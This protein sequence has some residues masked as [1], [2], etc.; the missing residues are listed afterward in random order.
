[1]YANKLSGTLPEAL[2]RLT[3]LSTLCVERGAAPLMHAAPHV[4]RGCVACSSAPLRCRM[5]RCGG[6]AARAWW[7]TKARALTHRAPRA[8]L[9]VRCNA[10]SRAAGCPP[11]ASPAP[12][13]RT[14][15]VPPA[16]GSCTSPA[17]AACFFPCSILTLLS[18]MH[19]RFACCAPLCPLLSS[20][21]YGNQMSGTIPPAIGTM[22][23]LV[24][25]CAP[26]CDKHAFLRV[27]NLTSPLRAQLAVR[28]Q[29][30]GPNSAH[31]RVVHQPRA[32]VRARR[33]CAHAALSADSDDV[34]ASAVCCSVAFCMATSWRDRY[35]PRWGRSPSCAKCAARC[36][37]RLAAAAAQTLT[38]NER[39]VSLRGRHGRAG[40]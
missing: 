37:R 6:S 22:T 11:I 35:R 30:H 29:I 26:V 13:T 9:P 10:L 4:L 7:R 23:N 21:L 39:V 38:A 16:C 25:L 36:A 20:M 14:S 5:A 3:K 2:T 8:L 18:S 32:A 31:A 17:A 15:G 28:E 33:V 19:S 24:A 12:S 27:A 1:M 40:T 34:L